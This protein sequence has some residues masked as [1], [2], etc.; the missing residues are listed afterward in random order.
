MR[1]RKNK[2]AAME[3]SVGTIVIIVLAMTMLILG[4]VL[5]QSIFKGA[6]NNVDTLNDKVKGEIDKLFVEDKEIVMYLAERT[7]SIKQGKT[8]GVAFGIKNTQT[9]TASQGQFT[10]EITAN[11]P[12]LQ[13][14]CGI[15]Q[16]EAESWVYPGRTGSFQ[17][18]PGEVYYGLS[19]FN[20]AE[21][22]TL[23]TIRYT[24][25]VKLGGNPYA[26]ELFDVEVK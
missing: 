2:K 20:I 11:D 6:K 8:F 4:L 22:S 19:K 13:T 21:G 1:L 14:Q 10:Y 26:T 12:D 3:L 25:S 18:A 17:L 5:I 16:Q 23:C 9:G 24:L 7:A 15:N